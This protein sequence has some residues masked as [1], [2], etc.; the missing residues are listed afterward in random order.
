MGAM[1]GRRTRLLMFALTSGTTSQSKFIPVTR[2]FFRE[3]RTGWN[4]WGVHTFQQHLD[5]IR[6]HV[7]QLSSDWQQFPTEA[8]TPCGNI[9]GL[10]AETAPRISDPIF[11]LPRALMKISDTFAKQYAALRIS[12]SQISFDC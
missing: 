11:I 9:S 7:V 2:D 5:L 12:M 6:K 10:A 3:Y 8:G 1:F 4:L